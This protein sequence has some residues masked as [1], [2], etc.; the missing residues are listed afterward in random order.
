MDITVTEVTWNSVSSG[1]RP[2]PQA[3]QHTWRQQLPIDITS[4]PPRPTFFT[5]VRLLTDTQPN[6]QPPNKQT[7]SWTD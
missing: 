6:A 3:H 5:C 7:R 2:S 1:D 4:F